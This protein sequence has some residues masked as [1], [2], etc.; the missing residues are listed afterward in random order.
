MP[1]IS[2]ACEGIYS[3]VASSTGP[4]VLKEACKFAFTDIPHCLYSSY[5]CVTIDEANNV[6]L[7]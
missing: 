4:F 2:R 3:S 1:I 7:C 5:L 6:N